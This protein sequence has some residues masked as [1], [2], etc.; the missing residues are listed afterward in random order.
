MYI[1][2]K[3]I[4]WMTTKKMVRHVWFCLINH[5]NNHKSASG[6]KTAGPGQRRN[7]ID[8]YMYLQ[9]LNV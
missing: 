2:V 6:R 4:T 3:S 7:K 9:K 8:M 1:I 5:K